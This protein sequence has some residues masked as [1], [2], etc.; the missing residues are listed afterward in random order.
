[1]PAALLPLGSSRALWWCCVP[2]CRYVYSG[3]AL[4]RQNDWLAAIQHSSKPA[5][6]YTFI[7]FARTVGPNV[8]LA[9]QLLVAHQS[10]LSRV[11]IG[12]SIAMP[13]T[14]SKIQFSYDTQGTMQTVWERRLLST[15][16]L[17][18]TGELALWNFQKQGQ[19]NNRFGICLQIG[20]VAPRPSPLRRACVRTA[21]TAL[22]PRAVPVCTRAA[23]APYR[24]RRRPRRPCCKSW[25]TST[26]FARKCRRHPLDCSCAQAVP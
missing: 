20:Y 6:P 10:W 3:T 12:T 7:T 5:G 14:Q 15:V 8:S 18:V 1:M 25:A 11:K 22:V 24:S 23:P 13:R 26:T 9:T 16:R 2:A 4:W 21:L 19:N 17:Q